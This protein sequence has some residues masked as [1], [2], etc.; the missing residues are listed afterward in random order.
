MRS[1]RLTADAE[2]A[3][4]SRPRAGTWFRGVA[5]DL[6]IVHAVL[7]FAL[8]TLTPVAE[9]LVNHG[10]V[11]LYF[12]V[13]ERVVQGEVPYRDFSLAYPPLALVP[14]V[15]PYL[16]WPIQPQTFETYQWLF[17]VQSALLSTA[18]ILMVGWIGHRLDGARGMVQGMALYL[19]IAA[20]MTPILGW[21]YDVFPVVFAVGGVAIGKYRKTKKSGT[22]PGL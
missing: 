13:A 12:Q 4:V 5:L 9:L 2:L 18:V 17:A 14:F 1:S 10:D 7:F 16:A 22:P 3:E 8:V 20:V 21:R 15:L 6:A 19:V 11:L